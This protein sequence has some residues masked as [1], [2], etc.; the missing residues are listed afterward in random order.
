MADRRSLVSPMAM[1]VGAKMAANKEFREI[2]APR[3]GDGATVATPS[4]QTMPCSEG[5]SVAA[6]ANDSCAPALHA[7]RTRSS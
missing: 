4:G 5:F 1:M 7:A 6:A 2:S 3:L